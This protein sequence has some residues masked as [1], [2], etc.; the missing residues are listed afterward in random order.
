LRESLAA[1]ITLI[2]LGRFAQCGGE[3]V[4]RQFEAVLASNSVDEGLYECCLELALP[5]L[6]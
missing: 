2:R 6:D 5:L 1:K 3:R 4:I